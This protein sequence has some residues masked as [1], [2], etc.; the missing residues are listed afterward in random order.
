[1]SSQKNPLLN[2][3]MEKSMLNQK[4]ASLIKVAEIVA[5]KKIRSI[6]L[7]FNE[8]V[9]KVQYIDGE[10]KM[11]NFVLGDDDDEVLNFSLKI[12]DESYS[13]L[14]DSDGYMK[15]IPDRKII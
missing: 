1:M 11:V 15:L 7:N 6:Q 8:S 5:G 3:K 12:G 2:R 4:I 9:A 10:K 14:K 13:G